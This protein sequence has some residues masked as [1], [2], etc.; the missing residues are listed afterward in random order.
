MG[1]GGQ[2]SEEVLHHCHS[3]RLGLTEGRL[4][5]DFRGIEMQNYNFLG[6]ARAGQLADVD[7][8]LIPVA[9]LRLRFTLK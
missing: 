7:S 4:Q 1:K 6:Q 3:L 2:G 8:R 9:L 5:Y